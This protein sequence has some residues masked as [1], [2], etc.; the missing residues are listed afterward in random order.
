MIRARYAVFLPVRNG[1]AFVREAIDSVIAQTREDWVLV[2]LDNASSDGTADIAEGYAHPRLRVHRSSSSLQVWE[3]WHRVWSMLARRELDVE[4][5]TII[6][7][8]DRLLPRFLDAIEQLVIDHPRA[9]LYQTAFDMIDEDGRIIRPSRPIPEVESAADFLAARLWGL[10]DSVGTGYVFRPADYVAVGGFPNLPFLL[11]ADDL[12]FARLTQLRFKASSRVSQCVYRLHRGSLSHGISAARL[13]AQI[14]AIEQYV[15]L[16]QDEFPDLMSNSA[17][18]YALACFLAREVMLLLPLATEIFLPS[19][20]CRRLRRLAEAYCE[21]APDMDYRQWLGTNLVARAVY[22][23][24]KQAMLVW[25][26][27]AERI[28]SFLKRRR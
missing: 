28:T 11:H 6:G 9:S 20:T 5:A 14:S 12:V 3:S 15:K 22:P 17:G 16:I 4:F 2:V 25:M 8:D 7:H 23:H 1:A 19:D 18:K 21:I 10:R 26:L 13:I 24:A 27:L